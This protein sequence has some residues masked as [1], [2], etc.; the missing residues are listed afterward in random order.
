MGVPAGYSLAEP[1]FGFKQLGAQ[2]KATSGGSGQ[3]YGDLLVFN[4]STKKWDKATSA[5]IGRFGFCGNT[6]ILSQST[7]NI[8]GVVTYAR[9]TADADTTCSVIVA[10]RILRVSDGVI[11]PGSSVMPTAT[12]PL[13]KVKIFSGADNDAVVGTYVLNITQ[14]HDMDAV[15]PSSAD[16]DIIVIDVLEKAVQ[17]VTSP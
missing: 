12:S 7:N 4:D 3:L 13:D 14:H 2:P 16:G 15:L 10:G 9:G 5:A 11:T 17:L 6:T 8:T 1:G